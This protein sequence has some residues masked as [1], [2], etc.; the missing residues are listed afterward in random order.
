[1]KQMLQQELAHTGVNHFRTSPKI[2]LYNRNVE[3]Q[4]ALHLDKGPSN[5]LWHASISQ[6]IYQPA[7]L[8][9]DW[10]LD[11]EL[12]ISSH[13][14]FGGGAKAEVNENRLSALGVCQL[15]PAGEVV[16]W[17]T[18]KHTETY[19]Y[20]YIGWLVEVFFVDGKVDPP[21]WVWNEGRLTRLTLWVLRDVD[22]SKCIYIF[23]PTLP[24]FNCDD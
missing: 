18:W 23:F 15:C 17:Y 20:I 7:V 13:F 21:S 6:F 8:W 24:Y 22:F 4:S 9:K 5:N 2:Q 12:L 19:I 1:M 16:G 11:D 10:T 14:T 3:L